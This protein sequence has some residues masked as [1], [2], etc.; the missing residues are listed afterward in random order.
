MALLTP[1]AKLSIMDIL[2]LMARNAI[3]ADRRG[4]LAFWCRLFVAALTSHLGVRPIEDIFGAFVVI[5]I[6]QLP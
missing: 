5:E 1:W 3:T 2:S 6:P 4:V